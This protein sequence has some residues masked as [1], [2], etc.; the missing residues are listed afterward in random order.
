MNLKITIKLNKYKTMAKK[1]NDQEFEF[2]KRVAK[3][4]V[5]MHINVEEIRKAIKILSD[6]DIGNIKQMR[7]QLYDFN[8]NPKKGDEPLPDFL[9][10]DFDINQPLPTVLPNASLDDKPVTIVTDNIDEVK[11]VIDDVKVD[12]RSKEYRDSLK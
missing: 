6:Q 2:V 12:K 7:K 11:K 4:S 9:N 10:D 8:S 5:N 1:L 3:D